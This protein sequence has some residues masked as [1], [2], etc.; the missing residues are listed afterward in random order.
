MRKYN[1]REIREAVMMNRPTA[2]I[3]KDWD[4]TRDQVYTIRNRLKYAP[5]KEKEHWGLRLDVDDP[6][7]NL[8]TDKW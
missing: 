8:S 4:V 3:T 6:R 1:L 7:W 5:H 2:E